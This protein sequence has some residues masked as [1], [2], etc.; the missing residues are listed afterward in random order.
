MLFIGSGLL[1]E[2]KKN[3]GKRTPK[4]KIVYGSSD[5]VRKDDISNAAS[6]KYSFEKAYIMV[7]NILLYIVI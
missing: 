4:K 2:I 3:I 6:C 1:P 7:Y 5:F